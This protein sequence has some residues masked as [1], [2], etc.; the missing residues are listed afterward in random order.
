MTLLL[1]PEQH[2]YATSGEVAERALHLGMLTQTLT[3]L[4]L[5]EQRLDVTHRS[6][7]RTVPKRHFIPATALQAGAQY[8]QRKGR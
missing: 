6:L 8:G 1:F 5:C 2:P 7:K 3:L 4:R